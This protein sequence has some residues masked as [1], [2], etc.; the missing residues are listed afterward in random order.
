MVVT[1]GLNV[2]ISHQEHRKYDHD[3]IPRWENESNDT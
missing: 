2:G 1:L 3:D